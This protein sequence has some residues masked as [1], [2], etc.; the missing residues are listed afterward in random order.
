MQSKKL[1]NASCPGESSASFLG[2]TTF[3][4]GCNSPHQDPD[5]PPFKLTGLMHTPYATS[6]MEFATTQLKNNKHINL[7]T[8]M[9]GA[10][11]V[12]EVIACQQTG[13]PLGCNTDFDVAL[14]NYGANLTAILSGIR[15]NYDGTLVLVTYYA[16]S[17]GFLGLGTAL[18]L[19]MTAAAAPYHVKIADAFLPFIGAE[20]A[21][22]ALPGDA[23]SAGLVIQLPPGSKPPCDIHPTKTG[24]KYWPQSS[25]W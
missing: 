5:F 17:P 7:V 16:P 21:R 12:L 9:I 8:L 4:L 18:N 24:G 2:L 25:N 11:D 22:G 10:N 6:Q 3:D 1:V 20:A 15:A 13:M 23:C 14:A 19:T